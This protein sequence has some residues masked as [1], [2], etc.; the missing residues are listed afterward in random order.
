M[1]GSGLPRKALFRAAIALSG[2]TAKAWASDQG[3]TPAHLYAVLNGDR[4]SNSLTQ[5]VDAF[6]AKHL[7]E[8]A[9]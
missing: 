8:R 4:E 5:K 3:I 9:A 6:I 2:I 7:P 1:T